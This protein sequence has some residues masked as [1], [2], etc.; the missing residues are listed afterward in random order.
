MKK[1]I[2]KLLPWLIVLGALACLIVFVF[3]PI[4]SQEDTLKLTEPDILFY[5]GPTD[6][7]LME[8]DELLFTMDP[9]TSHFTVTNKATG[10]V[11][12]SNPDDAAS[13]PVAIEE[14][15]NLMQSTVVVTYTNSSGSIDMNNYTFSI[16]NTNYTIEQPAENEVVVRY[17]IGKIDRV[18]KIPSA[19]TKENWDL[20]LDGMKKSTKKKIESNY[21]KY[22][23]DNIDGKENKEEIIAL[24][25]EVLNQTLYILNSSASASKKEDMEGYF[26]DAGYTD[27]DYQRDM[28]LVAGSR[29]TGGPVFNVTV[30]YRLEGKD[31]VVEIPYNEITYRADYPITS[32]SVLPMF[33][34]TGT[35]EEGFIFVPE[36]GGALIGYNNG[37]LKQSPYFSNI[38]GWNYSTYRSEVVNETRSEFPVFGMTNQ[39]SSFL[40]MLEGATS[41]ANIQADVSMRN[42]AYNWANAEYSI[43][44]FDQYNV[45]SRTTSLVFMYEKQIPDDTIVQRYRFFDSDK[46]T[47]MAAAYG[48]YLRE[49]PALATAVSSETVPVSVEMVGAIDK[50]VVKFGL[51]LDSV[52]PTTT[53]AQAEEMM[54]EMKNSGV[55]NLIVRMS[56]W[57]NGGINQEVFT[58]VKVQKQ[59]GGAAGMDQLIAA[60]K[61]N[62]VPLYFDGITCFAYN[63]NSFN[64]FVPFTDAARYATNEQAKID[65]Y[66]PIIYLPYSQGAERDPFYLVKPAYAAANAQNF[67]QALTAHN[68]E[69]VSF[70]DIGYLL[71]GDYNPKATVTRENTRLMNIQTL[72]D[73]KAAGQKVMIRRGN[74]YALPY[75]DII[76][77]MDM[78][79]TKYSIIDKHVPF[80]QI[81]LHGMKDY[82]GEPINL[83]GDYVNEFL[84]CVEYG[85][86][87]NFTFMAEDTRLLQDSFH[88]TYFGASF[89]S[90]K[91]IALDMI[92][93]YQQDTDGLNQQKIVDHQ[94]FSEDVFGTTYEDGTVVYVNYS[95]SEYTVDGVVVPARN[96]TVQRGND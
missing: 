51:P 41:Y 48:E 32:L 3:V 95:D 1:I 74:D 61:A 6:P 11:F 47:D 57:V 85:G 55:E 70:R 31:L 50:T 23:P 73:I 29:E 8:N 80:Y 60:A 81:A 36:G 82:T 88:S 67:V 71:S 9:A 40:C 66:D 56:G 63:S 96:Y 89:D 44:H 35:S 46:Y 72:A 22:G 12:K 14:S 15:K 52:V 2:L 49:D 62:G 86:G 94:Q 25:P 77:D 53:F 16:Q 69:G 18:Y 75:V 26:A 83:A 7:V 65:P 27:E 43:L 10:V 38:Y 21:S 68:A 93:R 92:T 13:D 19:I 42:N 28:L 54:L 58:K 76:T 87:L 78:Y 30:K 91:E 4:Y 84:K 64:G 79:G 37:K 17:A 34:A 45:S 20:L 5:D 33:G 59:L 90:W 39:G 24:Y